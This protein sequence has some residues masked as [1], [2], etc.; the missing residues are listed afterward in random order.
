MNNLAIAYHEWS[1]QVTYDNDLNK[2]VHGKGIDKIRTVGGETYDEDK[3]VVKVLDYIEKDNLSDLFNQ[4]REYVKT[5]CK[6]LKHNEI[7]QY[8]MNCLLHE[9]F[10]K[11]DDFCFQEE[12]KL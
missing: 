5:N 11:W 6:W 4:V 12:L 3:W 10:K 9:S 2:F 8:A 1:M 7:E